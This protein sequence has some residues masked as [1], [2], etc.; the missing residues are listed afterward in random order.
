MVMAMMK[1][2]V[3]LW[4]ASFAFF[5]LSGC[6]R[7]P[8]SGEKQAAPSA[9]R[10]KPSAVR[11]EAEIWRERLDAAVAGAGR[12]KENGSEHV[13]ALND[14]AALY[15]EG[16]QN[17]WFIRWTCVPGV[18]PWRRPVPGTPG[19]RLSAPCSCMGRESSVMP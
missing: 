5:F 9:E 10:E 11:K 15:A 16:L 7:A 18:I 12:E 3:S 1:K 2:I 6:D 4:A 8:S 19:K 17:G 13:K 14:V